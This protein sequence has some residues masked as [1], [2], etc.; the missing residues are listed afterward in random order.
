MHWPPVMCVHESAVASGSLR[1]IQGERAGTHAATTTG[2]GR[3][4]RTSE[5]AMLDHSTYCDK[6]GYL[7]PQ[8]R[9]KNIAHHNKIHTHP[10]RVSNM[11]N[12][13]VT[14]FVV[15]AAAPI[16]GAGDLPL[17]GR[18]GSMRRPQTSP[19]GSGSSTCPFT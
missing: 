6:P 8:T 17:R 15:V 13:D 18:K 2:A 10:K 1:C 11:V 7:E 4:Q 9:R 16:G 19:R 5:Q 12:H 14:I 3:A